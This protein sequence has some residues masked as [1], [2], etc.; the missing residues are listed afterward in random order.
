MTTTTGQT[1]S[2]SG[3]IAPPPSFSYVLSIAGDPNAEP[4]T[5]NLEVV[6]GSSTLTDEQWAAWFHPPT[7]SFLAK[8]LA[9][10]LGLD[11]EKFPPAQ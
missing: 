11:L 1:I 8:C 3:I 2:I 10:N 4:P 7:Q 6:T 9:E 5:E